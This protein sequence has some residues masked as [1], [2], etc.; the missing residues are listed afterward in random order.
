MTDRSADD[1]RN[2][3]TVEEVARLRQI[4]PAAVRA[5]LR[6]GTLAG[7]QVLQG[8]RT[9]WRIPAGAVR[10]RTEEPVRTP[11]PTPTPTPAPPPTAAPRPEPVRPTAPAPSA[12][13]EALE[14]EVR[15]LRLQL[16]ALAEAHR[17]LL[18][19][20]TADLADL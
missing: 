3:L 19:A 17:R 12:R 18:D 4:T 20:V 8:Q 15:R 16:A 13:V 6:A 2:F 14:A 7:E 1:G 9:V 11:T 10:R 5:Q